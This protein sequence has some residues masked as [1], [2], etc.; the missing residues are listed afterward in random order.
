IH[1]RTQEAAAKRLQA[2]DHILGR[3]ISRFP[4]ALDDD[5]AALAIERYDHALGT[6]GSGDLLQ[7]GRES[8]R[9]DDHPPRAL[10]D[11]AARTIRSS[12][13]AADAA[14]RTGRE[15]L[16]DRGVFALSHGGIQ[17]D[18]LDFRESRELAQHLQ[19]RISLQGFLATL[20][21]LD[22]LP[23]HEID[24]GDDHFLMGTPRAVRNSF[25][26]PTV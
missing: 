23:A 21:E 9:A 10:S 16:D 25:S 14:A 20:D 12:D 3:E 7:R 17:I 18:D 26:S 2:A 5:L 15:Q 8:S 19:G 24:A 1:V 4:P 22:D 13:A 11:Q 6:H